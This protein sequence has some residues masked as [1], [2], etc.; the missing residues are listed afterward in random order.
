MVVFGIAVLKYESD[1]T[2]AR[3]ASM[4][5]K[6]GRRGKRKETEGQAD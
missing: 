1:I 3:V 5:T 4:C 2:N 6:I